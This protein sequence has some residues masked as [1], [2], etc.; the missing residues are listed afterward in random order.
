MPP[1]WLSL[2][3]VVF[4]LAATGWLFVRDLWPRLRPGVP[5]PYEIDLADETQTQKAGVNWRVFRNE[6]ELLAAY[7]SV[8]HREKPDDSFTFQARFLPDP[9]RVAGPPR[10]ASEPRPRASTLLR[11]IHKLESSYRVSRRGQ[12]LGFDLTFNIDVGLAGLETRLDGRVRG[13]VRA[14]K[15]FARLEARESLGDRHLDHELEPVPVSGEGSVLLPL[16]PVSRIRGLRPGQTWRQPI[17]DPLG[18]ALAAS[19][20]LPGGPAAGNHFLDAHVLPELQPLPAPPPGPAPP[21]WWL[22]EPRPTCL[23][24]EYGD[25]GQSRTWVQESDGLVLR[26]E[27]TVFGDRWLLLRETLKPITE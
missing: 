8:T 23:V 18:D 4:W 26:Q 3:I 19:N 13:E 21:A 2:A 11:K 16:H 5:P 17:V 6:E 15:L 1:R 10:P 14:G 25:E 12:L 27:S 20:L 7:T 9:R 22:H 24:I